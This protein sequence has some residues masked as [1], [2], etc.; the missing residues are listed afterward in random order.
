MTYPNGSNGRFVVVVVV[1][2]FYTLNNERKE[3][4]RKRQ[5]HVASNVI[6]E[7]WW[8]SLCSRSRTITMTRFDLKFYSVFSKTQTPQK[9]S[10]SF[11]F[12]TRK[13]LKEVKP[14]PDRKMIKL[15]AFD[16]FIP[17]L[18]HFR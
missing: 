13:V 6:K 10:F 5:L 9:A 18:R 4:L 2:S 11:F 14:S 1:F 17:S 3:R 15:L 7:A 8:S 12:L 16:I